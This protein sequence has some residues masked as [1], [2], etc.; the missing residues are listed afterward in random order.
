MPS[1]YISPAWFYGYDI[2]FELIFAVISLVI[3]LFA[4]RISK[5]SGQRSAK[6]LG[7]SFLFISLAYVVQSIFNFLILSKLNE[8]ICRVAKISSVVL[9]NSIAIYTHIILWLAGLAILLYMALKPSKVWVFLGLIAIAVVSFLFGNNAILEYY[10]I[11]SVYLAVISLHFIENFLSNKQ[12]KT[13]LVALAFVFLLFGSIHF[14]FSVNH[15]I[16]YMIG[17]FLELFAYIL[18]LVN[19]YL[20]LKK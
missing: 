7:L 2:A 9:F 11:S 6:L 14:L 3:A 5:A 20:V 18:I 1:M 10:I 15:E 19:F 12:T 4:F 8:N 16:F 13:L 17:H